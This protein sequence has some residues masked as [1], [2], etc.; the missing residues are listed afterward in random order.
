MAFDSVNKHMQQ[1]T[2]LRVLFFCFDRS[3]LSRFCSCLFAFQ[4]LVVGWRLHL[5]GIEGNWFEPKRAQVKCTTAAA[6]GTAAACVRGVMFS[7]CVFIAVLCWRVDSCSLFG[8]IPT[9]FAFGCVLNC[10][11]RSLLSRT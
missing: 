9:K 5:R 8:L 7:L 10:V 3:C 1:E 11:S 4:I 6:K 2:A